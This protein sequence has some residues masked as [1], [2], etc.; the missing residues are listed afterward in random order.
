MIDTIP[1]HVGPVRTPVVP[2][3]G[4]R[5]AARPALAVAGALGWVGLRS[6]PAFQV[7]GC[8]G[9]ATASR[10][11][12]EAALRAAARAFERVPAYQEAVLAGGTVGTR[13]GTAAERLACL[14]ETDKASYI[15]RYPLAARC[16][17]GRIPARGV[18][19]DES[20]GSSGRPYTWVRSRRELTDVHRSL[21][22][23][24]RHLFGPDLV[25]LNGFSMGAWATGTNVAAA[26]ASNGLIKSPGP[27]VDKILSVLDLLGPDRTYL[28]AGYPPF[29][30]HLIETAEA[31]G[32]D[33]QRFRV[34]GVVGGEGMSEAQ[35]AHLERRL[36]SVYSAY[37]AS[38]LD[39]GVAAELPL[40]VWIRRQAAANPAL[41]R[42]LF[43]SEGRLPMLF[44]YNPL[45]YY[46]ET[47]GAGE[48]IFTV[49]RRCMLSPRIR[50]NIHDAGGAASFDAVLAICREFG[51]DPVAASQAETGIRAFRLPF[52]FVRGRSDSTLSFMGANIY[53]EDVEVALYGD[54]PDSGRVGAF[55]LE[56]SESATGSVQP[57]VHV[58]VTGGPVP[59]PAFARSLAG[60]IS[61]RLIANSRDFAAAVAEDPATAGIAV[62]LHRPSE[63]PFAH[64]S[65]RIKRRY[66]I[67]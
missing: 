55:C 49:N 3:P 66:V 22:L 36:R 64:N 6:W 40:S 34:H 42:A 13:S 50:Y 24:A 8:R 47:N 26:L 19:L 43:G 4:P 14:P 23:L 29:L 18:E 63:G 38:D 27:D 1:S 7:L 20:S 39:I 28:V 10:L 48:L 60:C 45:D 46:V 54:C 57:C 16:V 62:V 59:D 53:P 44:Q 52:L 41:A 11:S 30:R 35:R 15:D 58:E 65:L 67:Q 33:W 12:A 9:S 37:G 51:L 2:P 31:R 5:P 21:R 25:T 17:D 61:R 32:F 56:L